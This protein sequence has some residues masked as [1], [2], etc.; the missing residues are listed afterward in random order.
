[1][2]IIL[3]YDKHDLQTAT[4]EY[5]KDHLDR[6]QLDK[7]VVNHLLSNLRNYVCF[8]RS[9]REYFLH[10]SVTDEERIVQLI[11]EPPDTL[12][13]WNLSNVTDAGTWIIWRVFLKNKFRTWKP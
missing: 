8:Y 11:N 4:S 5:H 7:D 9:T 3:Y 2:D 10:M 6:H 1:M 13:I 12:N